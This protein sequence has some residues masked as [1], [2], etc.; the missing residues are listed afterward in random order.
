MLRRACG[1]ASAAAAVR[2][3]VRFASNKARVSRAPCSVQDPHVVLGHVR[4]CKRAQSTEPIA[5]KLYL[6]FA[7]VG[8]LGCWRIMYVAQEETSF[9]PLPAKK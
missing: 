1:Q 5:C 7:V 6:L 9:F 8:F 4:A 2:A 3:G